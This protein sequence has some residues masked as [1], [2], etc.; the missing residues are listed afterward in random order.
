MG[1]GFPDHRA[2]R[3]S[4]NPANL[5]GWPL[6]NVPRSFAATMPQ[7]RNGCGDAGRSPLNRGRVTGSP[8]CPTESEPAWACRLRW[9]SIAGRCHPPSWET[10][11]REPR[12][13]SPWVVNLA[14]TNSSNVAA[15]NNTGSGLLTFT[16]DTVST[17]AS[18]KNFNFFGTGTTE[19]AGRIV[20]N[21]GVNTAG[22]RK[23]NAGVLIL[24]GS[25]TFTGLT[26][27]NNGTLQF[28]NN[29]LNNTSGNRWSSSTGVLQCG[30]GNTQDIS[31]KLQMT[32]GNWSIVDTNGNHVM[33]A[34]SIG[35]TMSANV[36][37]RG[38]DTLTLSASNSWTG[39]TAVDAGGL[40]LNGSL[41]VGSS[42]SVAA[43]AD[44]GWH[45]RRSIGNRHPA[46]VLPA[47]VL[48]SRWGGMK[49]QWRQ[50]DPQQDPRLRWKS[51]V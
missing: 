19:F 29:S 10:A 4:E 27:F 48:P 46:F 8:R 40:V 2:G 3:S 50:P 20:D 35:G 38:L 15:I 21:S 24:S 26:D 1:S 51:A 16:S 17:A 13:R 22:I 18:A 34:T 36:N 30:T 31:P 25:N 47:T 12:T 9:R 23:G 11:P 41:A 49:G 45:K 39:S 42:L 32:A 14:S 6:W 5:A 33:F 43:A 37:K 7:T 44:A 28:A